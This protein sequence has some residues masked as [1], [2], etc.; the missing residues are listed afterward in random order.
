MPTFERA[1]PIAIILLSLAAAAVYLAYGDWR[2]CGYFVSGA[3]IT[4][5]AII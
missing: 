4:F 1:F 3:F 2:R 5:F